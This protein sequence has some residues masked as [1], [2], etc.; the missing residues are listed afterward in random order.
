MTVTKRVVVTGIGMITPLGN[1]HQGVWSA[2]C[3]GESGISTITAFDTSG[4]KSTLAGICHNFQPSE[5]F[6]EREVARLDRCSQFA[7][8]STDLALEEAGLGDGDAGGYET[9][10]ILGTGYGSIGSTE[11]GYGA[12]Y[13]NEKRSAITIPKA[14]CNAAASNVAIR[15]KIRGPNL[16]VSTAC[17]SGANAIGQAFHLVRHGVVERMIT[18]GVDAPITPGLMDL[19]QFLR[20]LSTQNDSPARAC[21]PFSA[22]RDGFVMAEGAGI[23]ILESLEG[24]LARDAPIFGELVGYASTSD[25]S[26]ITLPD[27][28]GE[29]QAITGALRDSG[30]TP[31]DIHYINA[32]GT[33]TKFNDVS[34]TKA[35]KQAFGEYAHQIPVSSIKPMIGHSMGAS[36]AIEFIATILSVERNLIPGTINY[37]QFDPECDLDYVT[38]GARVM[39]SHETRRT[40][41]SNSFG[42]GGNNAVLIV[43]QYVE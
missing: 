1:E 7:L 12:F 18:G 22:N 30:L 28:E 38:E 32:H 24:A 27:P 34:E 11:D 31:K 42:F 19:W 8:L 6:S 36:G 2:L 41:L 43:R 26:H 40:A 3:A 20:V 16:T 15:F 9:G 13:G 23:V 17:S 14:M 10:I 5:F 39:G 25:A 21:K 37:E 35:I 4:F 29:A 33:G